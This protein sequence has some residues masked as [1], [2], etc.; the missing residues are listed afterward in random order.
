[1]RVLQHHINQLR[2]AD[3]LVRMR[4]LVTHGVG[5]IPG[6]FVYQIVPEPWTGA[7]SEKPLIGT[8]ISVIEFQAL[9]L[10]PRHPALEETYNNT[11][12]SLLEVSYVC[13]PLEPNP[14]YTR[15]HEH[16]T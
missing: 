11:L 8:V 15:K 12:L 3:R 14:S 13:A 10:W 9:V 16:E 6:D 1:M 4:N 2:P 7:P 5:I